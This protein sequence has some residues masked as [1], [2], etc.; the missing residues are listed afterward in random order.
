MPFFL[1]DSYLD[2]LVVKNIFNKTILKIKYS[3]FD[4]LNPVNTVTELRKGNRVKAS[5]KAIWNSSWSMSHLLYEKIT[6]SI[7]RKSQCHSSSILSKAA[8]QISAILSQKVTSIY[9]KHLLSISSS[10]VSLVS[11]NNAKNY[12]D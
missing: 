5:K 3:M 6:H 1:I 8:S 4:T 7:T 2:V 11:F 12:V 10:S 9:Q